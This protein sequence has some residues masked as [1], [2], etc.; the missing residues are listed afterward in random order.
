MGWMPILE[1]IIFIFFLQILM[2]FQVSQHLLE[3]NFKNG[4]NLGRKWKKTITRRKNCSKFEKKCNFIFKESSAPRNCGTHI[5]YVPTYLLL[6]FFTRFFELFLI[7]FRVFWGFFCSILKVQLYVRRFFSLLLNHA[8]KIENRF[9]HS[10]EFAQVAP[11]QVGPG[12]TFDL[13]WVVHWP[14]C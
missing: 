13:S 3:K 7:F 8:S 5:M 2:I 12:L 1:D 4:P 9:L 11:P 10:P 14:L 6:H